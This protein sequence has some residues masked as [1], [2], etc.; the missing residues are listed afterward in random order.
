MKR[1]IAD[2]HLHSKYSRAVSQQMELPVMAR[3]A[4]K[5]G[6]HLL[7]TGDFTHPLWFRELK[8]K[9][10]ESQPGIYRFKEGD[11][12]ETMFV[13]NGEISS[14]YT[15]GG[16]QRRIH[17]LVFVPDFP[18]AEKIIAAL[19]RQ[20]ANLQSDGRPIIGLSARQLL[21]LILNVDRRCFLIPCHIWTPWYSLYGSQSGFDSLEEC[22]GQ[23]S[24]QVTAIETGLSSDPVMNWGVEE[25]KTRQIV[26]FSDAHSPANL[27]REATVLGSRNQGENFSFADLA[28]ALKGEKQASWQIVGTIE[29]YP[30]EGKY[31][32]D[33]HRAC[34]IRRS[35]SETRQKGTLCP[36]CGKPLTLGVAYRVSQLSTHEPAVEK[37]EINGAVYHFD[38]QK[39]HPPYVTLVPLME[40][41]AEAEQSGSKSKTVQ[42]L[43]EK[44]VHQVANELSL[45][46]EVPL[47]KIVSFGGPKIGEGIEKVRKRQIVIEPGFDGVFG[48][49]KIWGEKEEKAAEQQMSLF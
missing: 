33:G 42:E 4:Q 11:D 14:I 15:E 8:E 3:W 18:T 45:L 7:G 35:P 17:N 16:K 48:T 49:V 13:I 41:I 31:H 34:S 25:L 23:L 38:P 37:R 6:I 29:F 20:G 5:K 36:V 27:G 39:I 30:E 19:E 21:D 10:E 40:I 47:E 22:F 24:E 26:S 43:Y 44:L 1:I 32:Y 46:L 12:R 9:L 2:L 28:A